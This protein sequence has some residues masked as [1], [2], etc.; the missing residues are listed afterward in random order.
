[1][2]TLTMKELYKNYPHLVP[3]KNSDVI[4]TV[5]LHKTK[6][7]IYVDIKGL[8][9]GIIPVREWGEEG[10]LL[11]ED[12]KVFAQIILMEDEKGR[13][14]LSLKKTDQQKLGLM[15]QEKYQN[16]ENIQVKVID[17]NKGGL[18]AEIGSSSGFLP[19][20]QLSS[21]HYPRASGDKEKILSKLRELVGQALSVKII[22]FDEKTN[23]PIFSEKLARPDVG[24]TIKKGDVS[25]SEVSGITNFGIF[26]NLGDFD[27]LIHRSE[28][29]W[30]REQDLSKIVQLG[31][32][33]KVKVIDV[34]DGRVFLSIK[35]LTPD[36]FLKE[37]KK[38]KEG[39]VVEARVTKIAPFGVFVKV[40]K[41]DGLVPI[42]EL[43]EKKIK[44]PEEILSE[45]EKKKFKI[46]K[47]DERTRRVTLSLKQAKEIKKSKVKSKKAKPQV[48]G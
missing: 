14:I 41:I 34:Q 27:G 24:L 12:D 26:V 3:Y 32:K 10:D 37:I 21:S 47:I 30:D 16:K 29:S 18:I 4:E 7:L 28:A 22:G 11:K 31:Q 8:A 44:G 2:A 9:E 46:I 25:E 48:K 40:G 23:Q 13:P 35:Q 5:V 15:L 1:M 19:A 39:N 20:S 17:A 33:I 36:P 45:G 43:S 38:Y 6:S 42:F